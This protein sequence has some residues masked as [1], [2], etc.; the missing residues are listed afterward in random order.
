MAQETRTIVT[1]IVAFL[2]TTYERFL[3]TCNEYEFLEKVAKEL[4]TSNAEQSFWLMMLIKRTFGLYS[5]SPHS[6]INSGLHLQVAAF[7][8]HPDPSLRNA[9][10]SVLSSFMQPFESAV[11][12]QLLFMGLHMVTDSALYTRF[13]LLQMVKKYLLGFTTLPRDN[14]EEQAELIDTFSGM[15]EPIPKIKTENLKN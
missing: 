12:G 1:A 13:H 8:T 7:T 2:V 10:L 5:P 6:F 9:A 3:K 11:N 15:L 4:Q 14:I